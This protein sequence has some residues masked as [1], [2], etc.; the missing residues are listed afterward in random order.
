MVI[1][2]QPAAK[3]VYVEQ[4]YPPTYTT[5]Y[6]A[7]VAPGVPSYGQQP[8]AS[9]RPYPQ[10]PYPYPQQPYPYPQQP[11]ATTVVVEKHRSPS[12]SAGGAALMGGMAGLAGGILIGEALAGPHHYGGYGYGGPTIIE[13]NTYVSETFVDNN[14]FVDTT[15]IDDSWGG[16]DVVDVNV[17]TW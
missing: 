12:V 14:A 11:A 9:A 10:Q 17:D 7:P 1:Q 5:G 13:N 4:Q 15:I 16:G 3:S 6:A 8:Y 2:Q